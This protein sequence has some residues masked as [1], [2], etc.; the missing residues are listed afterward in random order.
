[1][2][3]SINKC[4]TKMSIT[5][6]DKASYKTAM[7]DKGLEESIP[8]T[9][10]L[11]FVVYEELLLPKFRRS[12]YLLKE[13]KD[14]LIDLMDSLGVITQQVVDYYGFHNIA[15]ELTLA[16]VLDCFEVSTKVELAYDF[17]FEC[18]TDDE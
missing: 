17:D 2:L 16:T 4:I 15:N 13:K 3:L 5:S 11:Q 9:D 8:S 18:G 7:I 6:L 1:M 12:S 10:R 14:Y